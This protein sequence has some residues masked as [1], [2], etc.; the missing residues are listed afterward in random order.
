MEN[1]TALTVWAGNDKHATKVAVYDDWQ[2]RSPFATKKET[3]RHARSLGFIGRNNF[4]C[5]PRNGTKAKY[6]KYPPMRPPYR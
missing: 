2:R 1:K 3:E 4:P 5:A 6:T